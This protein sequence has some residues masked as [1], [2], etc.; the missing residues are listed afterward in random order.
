MI[1]RSQGKIGRDVEVV[2]PDLMLLIHEA[3]KQVHAATMD[4]RVSLVKTLLSQRLILKVECEGVAV[5]SDA[6]TLENIT[7]LLVG[8][9]EIFGMLPLE[10]HCFLV[11]R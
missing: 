2:G 8:N 3:V 9:A 4:R 11:S 7:L 5:V 1:E 10:P 6:V